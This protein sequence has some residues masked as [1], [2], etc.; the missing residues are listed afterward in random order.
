MYDSYSKNLSTI[1]P[2]RV[3]LLIQAL[4]FTTGT[5]VLFSVSLMS[6]LCQLAHSANLVISPALSL[7][8]ISNIFEKIDR[9]VFDSQDILVL[10]LLLGRSTIHLH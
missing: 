3:E 6:C 7:T 5:I 9:N 2:D 1:E 10:D 8:K 4:E